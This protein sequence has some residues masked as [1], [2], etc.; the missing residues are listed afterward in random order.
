VI[1]AMR[2]RVEKIR[3]GHLDY[4]VVMVPYDVVERRVRKKTIK[5]KEYKWLAKRIHLPKAF[6]FADDL[7]IIERRVFNE[8]LRLAGEHSTKKSPR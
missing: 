8:L 3:I 1:L 5:E 6:S 7:V 2:A 4:K